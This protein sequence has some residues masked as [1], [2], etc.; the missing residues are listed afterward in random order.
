MHG[1]PERHS[2]RV[3]R[4][5]QEFES[6]GGWEEWHLGEI[7]RLASDPRLASPPRGTRRALLRLLAASRG[8][9]AT[10]LWQETLVPAAITLVDR[11]VFMPFDVSAS[12]Y[13]A[14]R[15]PWRV[16]PVIV[17]PSLLVL[18]PP[19]PACR[20]GEVCPADLPPELF[21][22]WY[23]QRIRDEAVADLRTDAGI[24]PPVRWR[25]S[26]GRFP[27][28]PRVVSRDSW[29]INSLEA[30]PHTS[31]FSLPP[32][33]LVTVGHTIAQLPPQERRLLHLL[34]LEGLTPDQAADE[35]GLTRATVDVL[36]MR[37]RRRLQTG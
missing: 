33:S 27:R 7:R 8:T 17:P 9:S 1:G 32:D 15:Q 31:L 5:W 37:I 25:G 13:A 24:V 19:D 36:A 3:R 34:M 29:L 22:G 28:Q 14:V 2:L 23:F 21:E 26:S 6:R 16:P 10:Q 30:N 20:P 4:F 11:Q 12:I 18:K 35:M